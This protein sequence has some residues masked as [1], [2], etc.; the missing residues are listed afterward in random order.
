MALMCILLQ[1]GSFSA[2]NGRGG[3][4]IEGY[5][6]KQ[7]ELDEQ[8][9]ESE[10]IIAKL[11]IRFFYVRG[12]HDINM[13]LTRKAWSARR[14]FGKLFLSLGDQDRLPALF[15]C[16]TGTD[17][18]EWAAAAFLTLLGIPR[19]T[20]MEDY[21]RSNDYLLPFYREAIDDLVAA[22]GDPAIPPAVLG[23]KKGYLN[24]AFDE[25]QTKYAPSRSTFRKGWA[26]MPPNVTLAKLVRRGRLP[27]S[28]QARVGDSAESAD[29]GPEGFR[30]RLQADSVLP[31]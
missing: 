9:D 24:A 30:F 1:S 17:R 16:T 22:G 23:V 28:R 31:K 26:S 27:V 10:A 21:L 11:Q 7:R 3:D 13:P 15:P 8:W 19:E 5:T 18:T 6:T 4:G 12:N 25:M 29:G 20:V 14:A 2:Q